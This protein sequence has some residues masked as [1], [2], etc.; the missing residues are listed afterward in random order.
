[1][2]MEACL[3]RITYFL[4][5]FI[6]DAFRSAYSIVC[7]KEK[8][9]RC[10]KESGFNPVCKNC[11]A[12]ILKNQEKSFFDREERCLVCGKFLIAQKNICTYCKSNRVIK[13]IDKLIPLHS[14]QLWKK[15]LLFAW[16]TLEKR[17]ITNFFVK[18]AYS[19]IMQFKPFFEDEIIVVPVP[20]RP[21]KIRKKGW[22]QIDEL[23]FYLHWAYG[24]KIL[25]LLKRLS[26]IQQKKLDLEQRLETIGNAYYAKSRRN[27]LRICRNKIPEKVVLLDDVLTTGSTLE[28]CACV[29][30][31]LGIKEVYGLTL[32][33]V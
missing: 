4:F 19:G 33:G 27:I 30:K 16:K 10:G 14:Y 29:L 3:R 7:L 5:S 21:G 17:T 11:Q 15:E 12:V 24:I 32:F 22:D 26:R 9:I 20:P 1:M 13:S 23:C 25:K 31:S 8:C 28:N 2:L 18:M 6:T